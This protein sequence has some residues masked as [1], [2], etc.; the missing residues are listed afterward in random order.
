M[1]SVQ[2]PPNGSVST[3]P[4]GKSVSYKPRLNYRGNDVFYYTVGDGRGGTA[5]AP[6]TVTVR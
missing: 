3:A 6:V 2:Q 5:T 1:T 4:G